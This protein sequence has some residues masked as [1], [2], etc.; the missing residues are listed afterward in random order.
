MEIGAKIRAGDTNDSSG[1]LV[2]SAGAVVEGG[3]PPSP[4]GQCVEDAL[5]SNPLGPLGFVPGTGE[6]KDDLLENDS[7]A[8][9][10]FR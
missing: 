8:A 9:S 2:R 10:D 1:E 6:Q 7:V 4:E 5:E 3:P